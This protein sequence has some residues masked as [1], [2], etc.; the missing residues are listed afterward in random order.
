MSW[1]PLR[2]SLARLTAEDLPRAIFCATVNAIRHRHATVAKTFSR[3]WA[4]L[5]KTAVRCG[6]LEKYPS[7]I[8]KVAF[9]FDEALVFRICE[10]DVASD[11]FDADDWVNDHEDAISAVVNIQKL[12]LCLGEADSWRTVFELCVEL[13]ARSD[14]AKVLLAKP[15]RST[16]MH[17]LYDKVEAEFEQTLQ[18]YNR[19]TAS[20]NNQSI[21]RIHKEMA[22]VG[23]A[24]ELQGPNYIDI[25]ANDIKYARRVSSI[26]DAIDLLWNARLRDAARGYSLLPLPLT[27]ISRSTRSGTS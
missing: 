24:R 13:T 10:V 5:A 7:D 27:R 17:V 12:R 2:N 3:L 15:L 9:Q 22:R 8:A 16:M 6:G 1:K 11:T 26:H 18:G 25:T 23:I 21:D 19:M 4:E 14:W 20:R